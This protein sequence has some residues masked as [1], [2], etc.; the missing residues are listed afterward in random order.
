MLLSVSSLVGAWNQWNQCLASDVHICQLD[1]HGKLFHGHKLHNN[2][3]NGVT[4]A[5]WKATDRWLQIHPCNHT[6][7]LSLSLSL[8]LSKVGFIMRRVR[9]II[10]CLKAYF[11]YMLEIRLSGDCQDQL[12][13]IQS[14]FQVLLKMFSFLLY[15][16]WLVFLLPRLFVWTQLDYF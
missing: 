12:Y 15:S 14:D 3:S 6:F 8:S 10:L 4:N 7:S 16:F 5:G 13:Q 11:I 9:E 1:S 2:A